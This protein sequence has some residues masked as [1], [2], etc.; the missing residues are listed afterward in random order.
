MW[1]S[2]M[3]RW[4]VKWSSCMLDLMRANNTRQCRSLKSTGEPVIS[5]PQSYVTISNCR[6]TNTIKML[7]MTQQPSDTQVSLIEF[8]IT[9]CWLVT[10]ELEWSRP[11]QR[12]IHT[13]T[14]VVVETVNCHE[15]L[16]CIFLLISD[17]KQPTVHLFKFDARIAEF[18]KLWIRSVNPWVKHFNPRRDGG[19]I[20]WYCLLQC[21]W[22]P[23]SDLLLA[24]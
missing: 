22:P 17:V 19:I 13:N 24:G 2:L 10:C 1:Q 7:Q 15:C 18:K 20:H 9:S 4:E 3:M 12:V 6:L 11:D 14:R 21:Y 5:V 23:S 8:W 16:V